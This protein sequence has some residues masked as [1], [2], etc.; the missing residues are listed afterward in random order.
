MTRGEVER[1][2]PGGTNSPGKGSEERG[3]GGYISE[4]DGKA[5]HSRP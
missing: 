3:N 1:E 4:A 2:H 5:A